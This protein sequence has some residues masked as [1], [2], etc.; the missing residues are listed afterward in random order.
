MKNSNNTQANRNNQPNTAPNAPPE[1]PKTTKEA[2]KE[3]GATRE[4]TCFYV[5]YFRKQKRIAL[6][7]HRKCK[8][9]GHDKVGTYTTNPDLFPVSNQLKMF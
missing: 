1:S 2:D 5:R 4:N 6:V 9:T 7:G 8:V 3:T